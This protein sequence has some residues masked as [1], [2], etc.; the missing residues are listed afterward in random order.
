MT[1]TTKKVKPLSDGSKVTQTEHPFVGLPEADERLA[2]VKIASE[3]NRLL[4]KKGL[5]QKEAAKLLSITQPEISMLNR[6]CLSGFN[7]D[8]LYRCLNAFD[9]DVPSHPVP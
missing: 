5:N 4:K 9:V 7:F 6:G 1:D 3:I 2:K 8:R